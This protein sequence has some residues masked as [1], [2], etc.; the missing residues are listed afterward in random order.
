[1]S[2]GTV[3]RGRHTPFL[4]PKLLELP[5]PLPDDKLALELP[6]RVAAIALDVGRV[7]LR[8]GDPVED[9]VRDDL[10]AERLDLGALGGG[11][12]LREEDWIRVTLCILGGG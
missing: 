5:P 9:L 12:G 3:S 1:M 7:P 11:Y 2:T 4:D 10:L 6:E 8:V